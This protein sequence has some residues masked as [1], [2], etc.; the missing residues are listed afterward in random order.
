MKKNKGKKKL[1]RQL[2]VRILAI[3]M[4]AAL[5]VTMGITIVSSANGEE[6]GDTYS[7][8]LEL[9]EERQALR[10]TQRL[11]FTNSTGASR[12][13][14]M[15]ALY[16]NQFRRASTVMYETAA[17]LPVGYYPGGAEFFSVTVNG[18]EADWAVEGEGEWFLRV[19][20]DLKPGETCEVGFLYDLLLT[21]NAAF[22]G[23]DGDSWRLSGF[24]PVLAVWNDGV[25]EA[26]NPVQ[27]CRYT[28]TTPASYTAEI[29]L[30]E[31][32]DLAATGKTEYSDNDDGTK[33]WR[34]SGENLR[35]FSL[36]FSRV[37]HEWSAQSDLG[38]EIQVRASERGGGKRAL[39][40]A[41]EAVNLCEAWFGRL[42]TERI[43]FAQTDLA[44]EKLSFAGCVWLDGAL[45]DDADILRDRIRFA[46]AEQYFGLSVYA[47]PLSDA[48]LCDSVCSYLTYLMT[49]ET[50]GHAAF[51][52]RLE[53]ELTD[54]LKV[55]LPGNLYI[56][57][58][59]SAFSQTQFDA[60]V[61]DRGAAA[62]HEFRVTVGREA[63]LDSLA[64]YFREHGGGATV[65]EMDF[66]SAFNETTGKDW[67]AFLTEL[68]FGMD[69]YALQEIDWYEE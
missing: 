57:A 64:R 24:Y 48:W 68:L 29:A 61:H 3:V 16:A 11:T 31:R 21:E 22:C 37:W 67:E 34:V 65:T 1:T 47:D 40:Y 69:E 33:T 15:F 4:A 45:F 26:N 54:S 46:V 14:L 8:Q 19:A 53:R 62:L 25:W 17:A 56:T 63:F 60:V 27:H 32:Y 35:E 55:T 5:L 12:D 2:L 39:E 49:E 13:R 23:V 43:V 28:L 36:C 6:L 42:P 30:P 44:T 38:T 10:I 50:E 51:A 18:Q 7:L 20:C 66:L 52:A 58:D 41:T 9:V 59:G